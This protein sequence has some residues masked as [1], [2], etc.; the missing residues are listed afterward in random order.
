MGF[1]RMPGVPGQIYVPDEEG[2]GLKKFPCPDCFSCQ[3]CSDNRC[4]LCRKRKAC[5][6]SGRACELD[7][8]KPAKD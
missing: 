6:P 8:L 7:G 5:S 3:W 4:D 2:K 1:I